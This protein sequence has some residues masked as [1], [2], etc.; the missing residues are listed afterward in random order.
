MTQSS[1]RVR[2][3]FEHGFEG[4]A[5]LAAAFGANTV[6]VLVL[7]DDAV[8]IAYYRT[9]A[10]AVL[11]GASIPCGAET[12]AALDRSQGP[13]CPDSCVARF[14]TAQVAP[15]SNS[16][17]LFPWRAQPGPVTIAF[18]FEAQE[19]ACVIPDHVADSLNLAALAAWSLK[20]ISRLRAEL[21]AV[22]Q[23]FAS[24]KT[25]ERAKGILQSEHGMSE[26]QAYDYLRRMSR[27]RRV[28]ISRLAEDLLGAA[29]WP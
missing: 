22:N 16:F 13:V 29:R 4:V 28:T 2:Y 27:Q 6:A 3:S 19:P 21:R 10:G 17:I 15:V 26:E 1:F 25:V 8:D 7:E 18:G 9:E 5:R 23:S 24:R 14:L 20:E 12:R 11:P